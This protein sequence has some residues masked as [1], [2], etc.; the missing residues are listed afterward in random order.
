MRGA[1]LDAEGHPAWALDLYYQGSVSGTA[2]GEISLE[3]DLTADGHTLT[4]QGRGS[5]GS[6]HRLESGAYQFTFFADYRA[7]DPAASE[8][9]GAPISGS[10]TMTVHFW[11]DGTSIVR[12][13][14][15][16]SEAEGE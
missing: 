13:D 10:T 7:S 15:T 12:T 2:S 3:F 5:L 14:A 6:A 11:S 1:A 16:L 9:L 8:R 4:Y